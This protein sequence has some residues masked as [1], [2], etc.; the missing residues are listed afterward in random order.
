MSFLRIKT[1]IMTATCAG[2][3]GLVATDVQAF[4]GLF[5]KKDACADPCADPCASS[6]GGRL[7]GLFGG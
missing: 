7:R 6:G 5:K 2:L 3:I 1:W 4:D